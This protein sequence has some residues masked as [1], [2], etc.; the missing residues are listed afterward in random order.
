MILT[1]ETQAGDAIDHTAHQA[2]H[3]A[4]HLDLT[5]KFR[6]ND[7]ICYA[8]PGGSAHAL[9][10]HQQ[11]QEALPHPGPTDPP[12]TATSTRKRHT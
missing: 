6:L 1:L 4:D 12:R 8:F 10:V 5:I 2:Q 7:V 3:L 11:E 9:A